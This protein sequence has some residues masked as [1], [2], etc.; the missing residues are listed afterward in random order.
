MSVVSPFQTWVQPLGPTWYTKILRNGVV[1]E[2]KIQ[3]DK[4][5]EGVNNGI[6]QYLYQKRVHCL[7]TIVDAS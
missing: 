1:R 4:G 3:G 7:P 5:D 2:Y 6:H